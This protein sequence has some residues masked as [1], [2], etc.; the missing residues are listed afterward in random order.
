MIDIK[1]VMPIPFLQKEPFTGS[2]KGMRYRMEKFE[3]PSTEDSESPVTLLKVTNWP[4]PFCFDK[5]P[6]SE[7]QSTTFEFSKE[8]IEQ[9]VNWLN[10]SYNSEKKRWIHK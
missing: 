2:W 3:Q 4:Q 9:A 10:E 8:G 7:K 5:T 1:D 6:D